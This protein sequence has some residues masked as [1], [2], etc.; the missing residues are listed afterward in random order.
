MIKS[1]HVL[2]LCVYF[3]QIIIMEEGKNLNEWIK[4]KT[5]VIVYQQIWSYCQRILLLFY[6]WISTIQY[7]G[8][9]FDNNADTNIHIQSSYMNVYRKRYF[10]RLDNMVVSLLNFFC[11]LYFFLFLFIWFHFFLLVL[12]GLKM[13]YICIF[14]FRYFITIFCCSEE[15][16][17]ILINILLEILGIFYAL[18]AFKKVFLIHFSVT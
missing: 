15:C 11:R 17:C 6:F 5:D 18:F 16:F 1:K 2:S 9:C 14:C 7:G 4:W 8:I 10:N 3:E 13:S 12:Y